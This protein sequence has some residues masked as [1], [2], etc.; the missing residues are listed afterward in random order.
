MVDEQGPS[1]EMQRRR[2]VSSLK[3]SKLGVAYDILY[4]LYVLIHLAGLLYL[5]YVTTLIVAKQMR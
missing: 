1:Y 5:L 3:C 2:H 4:V